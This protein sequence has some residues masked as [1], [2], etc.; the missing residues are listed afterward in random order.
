MWAGLAL[1]SV[2]SA[3]PWPT[4]RSAE[5]WPISAAPRPVGR[6]PGPPWD[7]VGL[8]KADMNQSAQAWPIGLSAQTRPISTPHAACR[9]QAWPSSYPFGPG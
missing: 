8:N 1:S 2:L 5:F 4:G 7:L 6:R 3:Q 9:A